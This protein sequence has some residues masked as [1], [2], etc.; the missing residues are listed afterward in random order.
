MTNYER[1]KN[2]SE[3]E[4]ASAIAVLMAYAATDEADRDDWNMLAM[5]RDRYRAWLLDVWMKKDCGSEKEEK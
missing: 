4:M 3:D 1:M 5:S 2:S